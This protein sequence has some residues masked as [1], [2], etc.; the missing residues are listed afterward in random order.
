MGS[1]LSL[2][3]FR[4]LCLSLP[5]TTHAVKWSGVDAYS[6]DGKLYALFGEASFSFKVD[7]ERFLELT[8]REGVVPAKFMARHKWVAVEDPKALPAAEIEAL[9]VRAHAL[10]ARKRV[11]KT[12]KASR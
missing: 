5:G 10:I 6:V 2:A 1:P 11:A 3:R 7:P 8:D 9:L 12:R 4:K